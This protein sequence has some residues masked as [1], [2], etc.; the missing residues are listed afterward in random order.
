MLRDRPD[1]TVLMDDVVAVD[2]PARRVV[3][4]GGEL[5]HDYLVLALGSTNAYFAGKRN[6]ISAAKFQKSCQVKGQFLS[7]GPY[8]VLEPY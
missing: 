1:T 6:F 5:R 4:H 3:L 7:L 8:A 2:L